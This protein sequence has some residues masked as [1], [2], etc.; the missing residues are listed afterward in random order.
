MDMFLTFV[1]ERI[2]EGIKEAKVGERNLNANE[3]SRLKNKLF[4][5]EQNKN[6]IRLARGEGR[7]GILDQIVSNDNIVFNWGLKGQHAFH[8][9]S[10]LRD[11]LEPNAVDSTQMKEIVKIF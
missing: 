10:Q 3:L 9:Q 4:E 1:P 6:I 7:T 5:A 8:Q 11:F 2:I